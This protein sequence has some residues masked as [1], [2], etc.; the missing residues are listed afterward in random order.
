[1]MPPDDH[2]LERARAAANLRYPNDTR[3]ELLPP[4][5]SLRRYVRVHHAEGSDMLMLLPDPNAA[6]TDAGSSYDHAPQDDPFIA[7]AT[8]LANA[9]VRA[10]K[11]YGTDDAQRGIWLEDLGQFHLQDAILQ[12]HLSQENA[13]AGALQLLDAFQQAPDR[14]PPPDFTQSK[15]LDHDLLFWEL[16]H[17]VDWRFEKRLKVQLD[18]DERAALR[19][20]FLYLTEQLTSLPQ[21]TVHRDFQSHNIMVL[22]DQDFAILDFQ[23]C[24]QG[25]IPYDAVALLRDSYIVLSPDALEQHLQD[26]IRR[27]LPTLPAFEGGSEGLAHAFHLQTIQRKLKDTGRFELFAQQQGKT[28]YLDYL[29]ASVGYIRHALHTLRDVEELHALHQ[30][31]TRYEPLYP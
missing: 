3:L 8:W 30:I 28:N 16:E 23:A 29:P 26:W 21:T 10:P 2:W 11:I 9:G 13:Y 15:S 19:K 1:M 12:K 17:Y 27:T 5:G 24:L 4:Y 22:S 18:S 20:S 7:V 25:P 31:L 14:V 6:A